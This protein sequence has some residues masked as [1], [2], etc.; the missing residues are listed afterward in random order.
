MHNM[1]L[2]TFLFPRHIALIGASQEPQKVGHALAQRLRSFSGRVSFVNQKGYFLFG[3]K[4]VSS[5]RDIVGDVDVAVIATPAATV[6]FLLED[7]AR[8]NIHHIIILSAGFSE[9]GHDRLSRQVQEII[10]RE[11]L[12]VLGPNCF[13][14]VN[15]KNHLDVT[16]AKHS[17]LSGSVAFVAQSG[18]LWSA[19]AEYSTLQQLG[20]SWYLSLGNMFGITFLDA[21]AY[22]AH[23][24]QTTVICCYIETLRDQGRAFMR[25]VE[26]LSKPVVVLKGGVS[27]AGARASLSHT[28]SLAGD[29]RVYA[30]AFPQCGAVQVSTVTEMMDVAQFLS[31]QKKPQG[32][33]VLVVSNAGGP[34]IICADLLEQY[35]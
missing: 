22:A 9:N 13:G 19:L 20:F 27:S 34:S 10:A 31:W 30:A 33:R 17:P 3:K 12:E 18:A 11:H 21:L 28:G 14:L 15:T 35:G 29:A 1:S 6:P 4:C 24:A 26:Q 25:A 5:V 32:K 2:H 23:D 8:H 7:C 16:Y